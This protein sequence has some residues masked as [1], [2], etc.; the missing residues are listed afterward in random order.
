MS[1]RLISA[2]PHAG[3]ASGPL[4]GHRRHVGVRVCLRAGRGR[5]AT[6]AELRAPDVLDCPRTF[7]GIR[8]FLAPLDIE[9]IVFHHPD[10][11]MV[12]IRKDDYGLNRRPT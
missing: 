7:D 3:P 2:H 10:G 1:H 5:P 6:L 4:P 11:R 9:G 12:K 8:E